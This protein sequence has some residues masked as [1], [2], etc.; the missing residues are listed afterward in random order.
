MHSFNE[1]REE[2][3]AFNFT[4]YEKSF[5][6]GLLKVIYHYEI[7]GLENFE[8]KWTFKVGSHK[9]SEVLDDE[10][11]DRFI[12]SLGMAEAISYYK[13]ACPKKLFVECGALDEWQIKWWRKLFYNGLGEFLYVNNIEV[14]EDD[15]VVIRANEPAGDEVNSSS[16]DQHVKGITPIKDEGIYEG[17]LVPV[18]GGKDSVVSLESLKGEKIIPYLL[19]PLE[20]SKK[21]VEVCDHCEE[22]IEAKRVLDKKIIEMNQKGYLNG[23]IPFSAVLAFSTVISAYLNGIK[24][25]ALSNESSANESTVKGSKVNHQYSKSFEF[26]Q[27]FRE[28]IAHMVETPISYF[29][30][31]RPLSEL[32]IAY[33]FSKQKR[34][35]KVFRS[36]N[37]GSKKGIWCCNCPKCLFVYII[38]SPFLSVEELRDIFS[39]DLFDKESLETYFRQL[40]DIDEVK[41]FECV[42]TRS[43]V[44]ASLGA[45]IKKGGHSYLTDKYCDQIEGRED[46]EGILTGWNDENNVPLF[47]ADKVRDMLR[48]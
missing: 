14:S 23:H 12:F 1:L 28:Y 41:P 22:P 16:D 20:A 8:T 9:S 45:F 44:L 4:H 47:M 24:Y 36:C 40:S 38:L 37:A 34:Y 10:I 13:C 3:R 15:L 35:H 46:I 18:G 32:Q 2:Y 6:D 39:E 17:T 7:I 11:L 25:I 33:I 27:D 5:E 29:S 30:L 42:G 21:C 31:L 48:D 43:E 19:N 26:E